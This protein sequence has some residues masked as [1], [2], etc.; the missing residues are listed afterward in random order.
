M[1]EFDEN[2]DGSCNSKSHSYSL[3]ALKF[4]KMDYCI[5][6]KHSRNV[7]CKAIQFIKINAHKWRSYDID[8]NTKNEAIEIFSS[9]S[10]CLEV[11]KFYISLVDS[12]LESQ[13]LK[14]GIGNIDI[15][16]IVNLINDLVKITDHSCRIATKVTDSFNDAMSVKVDDQTLQLFY[17]EIMQESCEIKMLCETTSNELIARINDLEIYNKTFNMNKGRTAA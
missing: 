13:N 10:N 3:N 12:L 17:M 4:E 9:I 16:E 11:Y 8:N 15:N 1:N 7:L 5:L 14:Y 6:C 2:Y